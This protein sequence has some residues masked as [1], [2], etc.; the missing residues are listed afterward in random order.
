MH[1]PRGVCVL[2]A[3]LFTEV[4][5]VAVLLDEECMHIVADDL[6]GAI[7]LWTS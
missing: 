6:S 2:K 7:S 5:A 3:W 1:P 4:Q